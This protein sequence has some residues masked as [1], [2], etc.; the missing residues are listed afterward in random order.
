[1]EYNTGK[2][3][4]ELLLAHECVI[5]PD[6]GGFIANY[7]PAVINKTQ[8]SFMPPSKDV[9]FNKNLTQNDGLLANYIAETEGISYSSARIRLRDY[10]KEIFFTL[11]K[12][13]SV[14]FENIGTFRYDKG[15][16]LQFFPD[17]NTNFLLESFGLS[18][19]QFPAIEDYKID[20][21]IKGEY[22]DIE[23]IKNVLRSGTTKRILIGIPLIAALALIP[24]STNIFKNTNI[25]ISNAHP[26]A[27][28][29]K[30]ITADRSGQN[31]NLPD[32]P[33]IVGNIIDQM[34]NKRNALFYQEAVKKSFETTSKQE[35]MD[36]IE[37]K[38]SVNIKEDVPGKKQEQA[39]EISKAEDNFFLIAGSFKNKKGADKLCR[40]LSAKG[41]PARIL[42]E[43]NNFFRVAINSFDNRNSAVNEMNRIRS[44]GQLPV[45]LLSQ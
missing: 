27:A 15:N 37:E 19:F 2:Y 10:V 28:T 38:L 45:W 29:E 1:M 21:T 20:K 44:E 41:Y 12:G 6:F 40:K 4:Y 33:D 11:R 26:A 16:I 35:I 13:R 23:Y 14:M 18:S 5:L 36:Y 43:K 31:E 24:L 39:P 8:Q 17:I 32:N 9:A 7:R 42:G 3:V 34:T 30:N 22:K 25:N